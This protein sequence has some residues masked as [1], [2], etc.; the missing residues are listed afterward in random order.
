MMLLNWIVDFQ[1]PSCLHRIHEDCL[2]FRWC[3][4]CKVNRKPF[5]SM[6]EKKKFVLLQGWVETRLR[7]DWQ[8]WL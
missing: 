1:F 6:V 5:A 8:D 4:I 3:C 7:E 2:L